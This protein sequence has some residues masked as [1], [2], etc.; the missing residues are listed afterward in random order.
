[1]KK[2]TTRKTTKKTRRK[3][4]T[5]IVIMAVLGLLSILEWTVRQSFL[6]LSID[7]IILGIGL[8]LC[9]QSP[10]PRMLVDIGKG[11]TNFA[12]ATLFIW[13]IFV[14]GLVVYISTFICSFLPIDF[15]SGIFFGSLLRGMQQRKSNR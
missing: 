9:V 11:V 12:I 13:G 6:I 10:R 5:W 1:M 14:T 3:R 15:L 2:G 8:E 7:L 4:I